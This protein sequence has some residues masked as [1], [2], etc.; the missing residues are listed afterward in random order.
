MTNFKLLNIVKINKTVKIAKNQHK[1]RDIL[2][3]HIPFVM[4]N[5]KLLFFFLSFWFLFG[6]FF[7]DRRN[8]N[9]S[10]FRTF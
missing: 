8:N 9:R 10:S 4:S 1:K 5:T 3:K 6:F 7:N 2:F